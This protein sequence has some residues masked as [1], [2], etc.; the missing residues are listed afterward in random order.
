MKKIKI[1]IISIIFIMSFISVAAYS[2]SNT[3]QM[4]YYRNGYSWGWDYY[5]DNMQREG[6][7][8]GDPVYANV[9]YT[10]KTSWS[11]PLVRLV[12][13]NGT[14]RSNATS[15]STSDN[16]NLRLYNNTAPNGEWTNLL[17]TGSSSQVGA[18][19][20]WISFSPN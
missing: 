16:Y 4:T 17:I 5:L 15:M 18:D 12:N 6:T 9:I 3:V 20:V 19:T 8:T 1:L 11:T 10:N 2:W 13:T 7:I 14:Y